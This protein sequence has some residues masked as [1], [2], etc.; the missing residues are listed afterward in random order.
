LCADPSD[1]IGVLCSWIEGAD[2]RGR[3]Q[4]EYAQPDEDLELLVGLLTASNSRVPARLYQGPPGTAKAAPDA[5]LLATDVQSASLRAAKGGPMRS[6]RRPFR[7][8]GET[9]YVLPPPIGDPRWTIEG[10][11]LAASW[12]TVPDGDHLLVWAYESTPP[13][14]SHEFDLSQP[15]LAA[16]D[17]TRATLDTHMPGYKPEWRID[18][19]R[20]YA[21]QLLAQQVSDTYIVSTSWTIENVAA[22]QLRQAST[23]EGAPTGIDAVW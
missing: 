19:T 22:G 1:D 17:A 23:A 7:V 3:W 2:G 12:T 20:P 16:S 5:A 11:E 13:F 9:A 14:S 8:G 15:F 10:G 21:R 18:L 4:V 6:L